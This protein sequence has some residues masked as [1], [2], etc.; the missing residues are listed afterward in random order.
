MSYL[1]E[2]RWRVETSATQTGS[3]TLKLKTNPSRFEFMQSLW[4]RRAL[5]KHSAALTLR[6][7]SLLTYIISTE[8]ICCLSTTKYKC[9]LNQREYWRPRRQKWPRE[10]DLFS[11]LVLGFGNFVLYRRSS[12]RNIKL[13]FASP[14]RQ[15]TLCLSHSLLEILPKNVFWS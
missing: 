7:I 9:D 1:Y 6:T 10:V 14:G 3:A 8:M 12:R 2:M 4:E 11:L 13:P 5:F 15:G